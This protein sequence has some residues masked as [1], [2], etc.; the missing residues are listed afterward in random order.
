M[1]KTCAFCSA[2]FDGDG[3]P[4]GLAVGRRFALDEWKG[5][6]WVVCPRCS[7]WNL[8]PFD[9]RLE[10][11]DTLA[12]AARE[13]RILAATGQVTLIRW[14]RYDLVQLGKPPRVELATWR[15]GERLRARARER[16]RVVLPL[17]VAALGLG[18]AVNVAAGG[19]LGI[20]VWNLHSL[21]EAAYVGLV[22]RRK[23]QFLE[24]PLCARCGTVMQLRARHV[25]HA[26]LV[27]HAQTDIALVVSCPHCRRE[28]AS[29]AGDDAAQALRQGLTYLNATRNGRRR[30]EDAARVVDQ[31]GGAEQL[32]RDVAR[33]ELTLRA[34]PPD[35]RLALEMAVDERAELRELERHWREAE[36]IA[37]IA[38]GLF[39][40]PEVDEH[41]KRLRERGPYQPEG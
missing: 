6:L 23:V 34:L 35:R 5:R 36:E 28:G 8:T 12:R 7:R 16:A 25:Q 14:G 33:S 19:S 40:P 22:G 37:E 39:T 13:G 11:I 41:L 32:V 27:S 9:D 15:Y 21:A 38:D 31:T 29:L 20:F 4:S 3:G 30:A 26:R 2:P 24:P 18:V 10:Q 1:Y 17:T